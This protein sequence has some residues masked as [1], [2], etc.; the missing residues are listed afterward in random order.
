[1]AFSLRLLGDKQQHQA[2]ARTARLL[3][4]THAFAACCRT[5]ATC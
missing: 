1:M 2:R 5:H 3:R 4:F